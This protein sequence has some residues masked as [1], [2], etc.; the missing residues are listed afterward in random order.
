MSILGLQGLGLDGSIMRMVLVVI[1]AISWM[2]YLSYSPKNRC[3]TKVIIL[4]AL[5]GALY[6]LTQLFYSDKSNYEGYMGQFLRWGADCVSSVVIGMTL[7]KL[8]NYDLFHKILP[9]ECLVLTPFMALSTIRLGTEQAM[10]HLDGGFNYQSVA[11][12]MAVLFCISLYYSFIYQNKKQ[13]LIVKMVMLLAMLVQAACCAM[14]GGRGG[15]VLLAVYI[16]YMGVYLIRNNIV[17][18]PKLFF[19]T[20]VT[21]LGFFIVANQLGVWGSAGFARSSNAINDNDRW[22]LWKEFWVYIARNPIIGHGLGGDY[23]TWGFYSHNL[24]VDLLLEAGLIGAIIILTIYFKTYKRLLDLSTNN[25]VFVII[26]IMFIYGVV[27]N[28]F[29]GYWISTNSNWLAFGVAYTSVNYY[30]CHPS[31]TIS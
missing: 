26:I 5:F 2:F 30:S 15:L 21:V 24:I 19:F 9:W 8:K 13:T 23:F 12:A 29:S 11:Y 17:S 31:I 6:F 27:M 25:Q 16:V 20:I 22:L 4:L 3:E 1:A 10:M 28:M 18:K 7:M 14:A